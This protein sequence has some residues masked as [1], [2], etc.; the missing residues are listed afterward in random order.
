MG[1]SPRMNSVS[2]VRQRASVSV[3]SIQKC[4][5]GT[6]SSAANGFVTTS[7]SASTDSAIDVAQAAPGA[8]G[9]GRE[10]PRLITDERPS[11][12]A[13][14]IANVVATSADT[15]DASSETERGSSGAGGASSANPTS[16]NASASAMPMT[17]GTSTERSHTS[18]A[19]TGSRRR[20]ARASASMEAISAGS[21]SASASSLTGQG[22][23]S[24]PANWMYAG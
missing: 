21:T 19:A 22:G 17:N 4:T 14:A 3:A 15:A 1:S 13:S 24:L 8:D 5:A 23:S 16:T 12:H 9:S 2:P 20:R 7:T 6:S 10:A 11:T 18:H